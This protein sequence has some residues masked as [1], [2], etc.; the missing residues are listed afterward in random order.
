V[1]HDRGQQFGQADVDREGSGAQDLRDGVDP[2]PSVAS[3]QPVVRWVLRLDAFGNR[4]L[5][6]ARREL[7][8]RRLPATR[9]SHDAALELDLVGG[10]I[11]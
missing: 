7:R 8:E 9:V 2:Q 3:D 6:R 5:L 4:K 10:H 1:E 11:P